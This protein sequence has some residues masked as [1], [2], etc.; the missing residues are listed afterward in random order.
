MNV[1]TSG[2]LSV[3]LCIHVTSWTLESE[4]RKG[5]WIKE[6]LKNFF[7]VVQFL[8]SMCQN[9]STISSIKEEVKCKILLVKVYVTAIV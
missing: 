4:E 3:G 6:K 7:L 1:V 2:M 5:V 9:M 8:L